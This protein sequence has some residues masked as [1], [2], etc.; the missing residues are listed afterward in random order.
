VNRN[1]TAVGIFNFHPSKF[2]DVPT[3]E[4]VEAVRTWRKG[5]NFPGFCADVFY[6]RPL[7]F[8]TQV[9]DETL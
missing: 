4:G 6:E 2:T 7:R 3:R 1:G 5:V 8:F 9:K